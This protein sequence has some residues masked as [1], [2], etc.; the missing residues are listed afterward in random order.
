MTAL[1]AFEAAARNGSFSRA[2]AELFVSQAA[3]SHQ[4]KQIEEY[5]G[6]QLF[7]RTNRTPELTPAGKQLLP[8]VMQAFDQIDRAT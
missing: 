5:L 7:V 2:A 3:I 8:D 6:V 1:K 4:I